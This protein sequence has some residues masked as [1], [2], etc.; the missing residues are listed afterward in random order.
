MGI[1]SEIVDKTEI[2]STESINF[3]DQT[4]ETLE[5]SQAIVSELE[6]MAKDGKIEITIRHKESK[7]GNHFVDYIQFKRIN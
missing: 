1:T 6:K 4:S 3:D 5:R 7:T 2:G